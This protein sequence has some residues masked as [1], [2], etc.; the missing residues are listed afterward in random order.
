MG[1]VV[2][3]VDGHGG[4]R[5]PS[6]WLR[7]IHIVVYL[8]ATS[9]SASRLQRR[10]ALFQLDSF[11]TRMIWVIVKGHR[12]RR[13]VLPTTSSWVRR[14]ATQT[15]ISWSTLTHAVAFSFRLFTMMH[16]S[17]KE[18][19]EQ[20]DQS[21]TGPLIAAFLWSLDCPVPTSFS[22]T[23][24]LNP[25]EYTHN[26]S[27]CFVLLWHMLTTSMTPSQSESVEWPVSFDVAFFFSSSSLYL[28]VVRTIWQVQCKITFSFN[29]FLTQTE[30]SRDSRVFL[31]IFDV[32]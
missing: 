28:Q 26:F 31:R 23:L 8:T 12:I 13:G 25:I 18:G 9:L 19:A 1:P 15:R 14:Y 17:V 29:C 5:G 20:H 6:A 11:S 30:R 4:W 27:S 10:S 32:G 21:Y 2:N 3:S 24:L 16:Q 22:H 7:D